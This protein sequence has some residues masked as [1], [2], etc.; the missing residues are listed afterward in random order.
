MAINHT[1]KWALIALG[2]LGAAF[3]I[4]LLYGLGVAF[5]FWQ[6]RRPPGVSTG[7]H[8]VSRIEDGTWFECSVDSKRDV[9]VCKAWDMNGQLIA[10]GD[11]RVECE[12]R[13]AI[14]SELRPSSVLSTGGRAY[15]IYLFGD[16][17][18][19]SKSLVPVSR[20]GK[21]ECPTVR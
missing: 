10:A 14:Q 3:L 9:D 20:D 11:F 5:D 6:P 7:A 12:N 4:P 2:G 17:G 13:A 21:T 18:P 15:L 8:Y 16:K 1:A 19:E